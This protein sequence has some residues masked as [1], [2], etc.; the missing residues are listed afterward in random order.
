MHPISFGPAMPT[1]ASSRRPVTLAAL[2]LLLSASAHAD[3]F[4]FGVF[5]NSQACT[6]WSQVACW[7]N[8]T[9][10]AAMG[11]APGPDDWVILGGDNATQTAERNDRFQFVGVHWLPGFGGRG[12]FPSYFTQRGTLQ[13]LVLSV[14]EGRYTLAGGLGSFGLVQVGSG[15]MQGQRNDGVLRTPVLEVT[16]GRLFTSGQIQV[17]DDV[18]DLHARSSGEVRLAGT[19]TLDALGGLQG[20]GL[21]AQ[22]V[23]STLVMDGGTLNTPFIRD[24]TDLRVG[25]TAGRVGSL[26][27]ASGKTAS[28]RRLAVGRDGG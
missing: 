1:L 13:S 14:G 6:R 21:N 15:S 24:F 5:E 18:F 2:A 4:L 20:A 22:Y 26:S 23:T 9:T 19:G 28:T 17:G 16:G 12:S 10:G 27:L 8:F 25:S 3:V 7:R 11:R